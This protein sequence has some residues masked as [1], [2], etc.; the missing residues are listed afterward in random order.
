MN[1]NDHSDVTQ[2]SFDKVV[3]QLESHEP[4][5]SR[6]GSAGGKLAMMM[7]LTAGLMADDEVPYGYVAAPRKF[8]KD[9]PTRKRR[10]KNKSA[11]AER[12]RQ[13]K[14]KKGK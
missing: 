11:K 2:E 14:L 9:A 1:P 6:R 3:D 8:S 7:G 12:Q 13:R 5:K 4:R 10:S